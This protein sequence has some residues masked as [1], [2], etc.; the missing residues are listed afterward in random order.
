MTPTS[1]VITCLVILAV[2]VGSHAPGAFGQE[3]ADT[4]H[5][6][7]TGRV[8]DSETGNPV[9]L[10]IIQI[11]DLDLTIFSDENGLFDL[12]DPPRGSYSLIVVKLGYEVAEGDFLV[13]PQGS[14]QVS[15]VPS[16]DEVIAGEGRLGGRITD[17]Q[18]GHGVSGAT[19]TLPDLGLAQITSSRGAFEFREMLPGLHAMT[20]EHLGYATRHDTVLLAPEQ[21]LQVDFLLGVEP[22][23]VEGI[24]VSVRSRHLEIFGFYRRMNAGNRG[25]RWTRADIE[26]RRPFSLRELVQ[27]VP[28]VMVIRQGLDWVAMTPWE[29]G[30]RLGVYLD[31]MAMPGFDFNRIRPEYV[32]ALEVYHE[33]TS[34]PIEYSNRNPCGLILIWLRRGE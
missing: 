8:M 5:V 33:V 31:G 2:L 19:V 3:R 13:D 11:P 7:I 21:S 18:T 25:R 15:L 23:P 16:D 28:G 29:G 32:E 22:I 10:A 26:E 20:V 9:T 12:P 34:V 24:T 17:Y 4:T 14:V 6:S 30:C 27:T 1:R